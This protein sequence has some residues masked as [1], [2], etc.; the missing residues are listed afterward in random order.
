MP[1]LSIVDG[2]IQR[3]QCK[4]NTLRSAC[5]PCTQRTLFAADDTSFSHPFPLC[6]SSEESPLSQVTLLAGCSCE[7][8]TSVE[9]CASTVVFC[10]CIPRLQQDWE[11][12]QTYRYSGQGRGRL[13]NKSFRYLFWHTYNDMAVAQLEVDPRSVRPIQW[14]DTTY[15]A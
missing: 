7:Q 8:S 12:E 4:G 13:V 9:A 2:C 6:L 3:S 14:L 1:V 5:F 11:W 15:R 10:Y